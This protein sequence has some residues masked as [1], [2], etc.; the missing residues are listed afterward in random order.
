MIEGTGATIAHF[1][2]EWTR[3]I[4]VYAKKYKDNM[5]ARNI[6]ETR[7][8][9]EDV[10]VDVITKYDR[11][12]PGAQITAKGAV[13]K[14]ISVTGTDA[15]HDIFQ[16]SIGFNISKKDLSLDPERFGR[17][18]DVALKEI[19]RAEDNIMLNGSAAHGITGLIAAPQANSNGKIV[20]AGAA[21]NDTN[22]A[23]AW[24]GEAGTDIYDDLLTADS[25]FDDEF[26]MEYL[27]G[28]KSDMRYLYRLDAERNPY[29]KLSSPLFG[30]PEES[31]DW[32][33]KTNFIT[34]GKVYAVAKDFTA[35]ELVVS[36]NPTITPLYNGGLGPGS[37]YYFEVAEWVVPEFHNNDGFVEI[38]IL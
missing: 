4:A 17:T 33:W 34:A 27:M 25:K 21:G 23:G 5:T 1:I 15:K 30:K 26:T 14:S 10:A 32:M 12:G 29:R 28:R 8:V 36:E 11:T 2:E 7:Y 16:I 19:H 38:N 9:G 31:V 24:A 6:L 20:N 37:N 3:E 35:G 18:I 22:N 13:P